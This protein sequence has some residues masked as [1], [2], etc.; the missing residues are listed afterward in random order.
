MT[1][2]RTDLSGTEISIFIHSQIWLNFHI[3]AEIHQWNSGHNFSRW[4]ETKCSLILFSPI[5]T[6]NPFLAYKTLLFRGRPW[7]TFS[8]FWIEI[9]EMNHILKSGQR[10]ESEHDLRGRMKIT[11]TFKTFSINHIGI[12]TTVP[13][14]F[15]CIT[16]SVLGVQILLSGCLLPCSFY[17]Y[18]TLFFAVQI[19]YCLVAKKQTYNENY[20]VIKL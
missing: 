14:D 9:Y 18:W 20:W 17:C 19:P 1:A 13:V 4:S 15:Y 16:L 8:F 3:Q 2:L 6:V 7:K 11:F 12:E 10:H 5:L